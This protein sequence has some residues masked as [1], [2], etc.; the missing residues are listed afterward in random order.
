MVCLVDIQVQRIN[1]TARR[2]TYI[3]GHYNPSIRICTY[4]VYVN[5]MQE[6]PNLQFKIDSEQQSSKKTFHGAFI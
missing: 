5:F 6:W 4:V 2:V 3:V 1:I